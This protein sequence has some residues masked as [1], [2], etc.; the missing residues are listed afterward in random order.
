ME[1]RNIKILNVNEQNLESLIKNTGNPE[2]SKL[3]KEKQKNNS[4]YGNYF[5]AVGYEY[6]HTGTK[7]FVPY[8][9]IY[10]FQPSL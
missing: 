4:Q 2:E 8:I 3:K 10:V 6:F 5:F 1:K 7:I 9:F